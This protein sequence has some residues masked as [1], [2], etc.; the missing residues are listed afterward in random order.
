MVY[1]ESVDDT[2]REDVEGSWNGGDWEGKV[3]GLRGREEAE[4]DEDNGWTRRRWRC[5]KWK[6]T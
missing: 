6:W 2:V 5:C 3:P 1:C 4:A